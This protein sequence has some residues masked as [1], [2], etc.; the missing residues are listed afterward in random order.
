[1]S[2]KLPLNANFNSGF[3]KNSSEAYE[4]L[5]LCRHRSLRYYQVPLPFGAKTGK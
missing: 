4:L 1:M 3:E 5:A 2:S